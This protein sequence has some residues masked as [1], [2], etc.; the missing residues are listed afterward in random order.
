MIDEV[1][2]FNDPCI[3]SMRDSCVVD[4]MPLR[5]AGL[6]LARLIAKPRFTHFAEE[7]VQD[8]NEPLK[9]G[10]EILLVA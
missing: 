9:G 4:D 1:R 7:L 6:D 3:P 2:R 8:I 10:P 5:D